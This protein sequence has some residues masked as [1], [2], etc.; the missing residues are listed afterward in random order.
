VAMGLPGTKRKMTVE[1]YFEFEE[2][3]E[4]EARV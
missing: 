2:R 1:E 3:S 4:G